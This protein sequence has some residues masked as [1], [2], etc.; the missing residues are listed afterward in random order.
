MHAAV[1]TRLAFIMHIP[2]DICAGS[3][4]KYVVYMGFFLIFHVMRT[5][6]DSPQTQLHHLLRIKSAKNLSFYA[7]LSDSSEPFQMKDTYIYY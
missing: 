5:N 2:P 7:P 1:C 4:G 3:K 6:Q